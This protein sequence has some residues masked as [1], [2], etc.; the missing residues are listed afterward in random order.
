VGHAE[1]QGVAGADVIGHGLGE[2]ADLVGPRLGHGEPP[3]DPLAELGVGH[4]GKV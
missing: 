3:L 2:G 4:G 1:V